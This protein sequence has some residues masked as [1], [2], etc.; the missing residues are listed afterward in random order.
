M[1]DKFVIQVVEADRAF[2]RESSRRLAPTTQALLQR[3]EEV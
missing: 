2:Y 1:V 3:Q